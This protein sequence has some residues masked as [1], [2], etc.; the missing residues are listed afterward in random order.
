MDIHVG[1][2]VNLE[3]S[4]FLTLAEIFDG[5][6]MTVQNICYGSLFVLALYGLVV[7]VQCLVSLAWYVCSYTFNILAAVSLIDC[8]IY[9]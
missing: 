2:I 7:S 1:D 6:I 3:T 8:H 5:V 4:L 9:A